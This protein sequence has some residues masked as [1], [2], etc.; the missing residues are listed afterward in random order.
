MKDMARTV[1]GDIEARVTLYETWQGG[2]RGP[3]PREMLGCKMVI[4]GEI[5]DVRLYFQSS[6]PLRPGKSANV[7]IGFLFPEHAK[8]HVEVGKKFL[9]REINTIGEGVIRRVLMP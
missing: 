2:R 4:D 6:G 8:T 5:L 9:L 3:T 1:K 7:A